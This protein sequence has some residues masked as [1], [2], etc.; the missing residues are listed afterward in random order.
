MQTLTK[1]DKALI[2]RLKKT[3]PWFTGKSITPEFLRWLDNINKR[4]GKALSELAKK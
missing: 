1:K 4:Y 3:Y 2:E